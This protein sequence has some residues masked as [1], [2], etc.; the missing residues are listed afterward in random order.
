MSA[1]FGIWTHGFLRNSDTLFMKEVKASNPWLQAN[2]LTSNKRR[3]NC[4]DGWIDPK[5]EWCTPIRTTGL[6]WFPVVFKLSHSPMW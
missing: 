4:K 6:V 5:G 1:S 2:N 3:L